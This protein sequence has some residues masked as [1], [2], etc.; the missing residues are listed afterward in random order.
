[1]ENTKN[2]DIK[3][4]TSTIKQSLDVNKGPTLFGPINPPKPKEYLC[5]RCGIILAA[6]ILWKDTGNGVQKSF[7]GYC[8]QPVVLRSN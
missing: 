7:C 4:E 5:P 1:M 8:R 6:D 2:L 3:E